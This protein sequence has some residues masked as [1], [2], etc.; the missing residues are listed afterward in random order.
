[1]EFHWALLFGPTLFLLYINDLPDGIVSKLL[2]MY[3]DDTTLKFHWMIQKSHAATA[4]IV[5][6]S[7]LRSTNYHRM[8]L[9]M[10][11]FFQILQ[12]P[13][14]STFSIERRWLHLLTRT[15]YPDGHH[16]WKP[17]FHK[18]YLQ[19]SA[20]YD[21]WKVGHMLFFFITSL[22]ALLNEASVLPIGRDLF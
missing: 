21:G 4:A 20:N 11:C 8:G 3:A 7:Q 22:H 19:I 18:D 12:Y 17:S 15:T 14:Y 16:A 1:M 5:W 10:A 13:K 2:V 9:E 6:Y